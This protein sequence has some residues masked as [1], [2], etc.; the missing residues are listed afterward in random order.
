MKQ[1][2]VSCSI[3]S[4]T[5]FCS[6]GGSW[7]R[8]SHKLGITQPVCAECGEFPSSYYIKKRV[9]HNLMDFRYN[10]K[11]LKIRSVE[12]ALA[13]AQ[14]IEEEVRAGSFD[15]RKYQARK[16]ALYTIQ[17][18][19]SD[20]IQDHFL[21]LPFLSLE[22]KMFLEDFMAPYFSEVGVF[23]ACKVHLEDFVR[24]FKLRGE[25]ERMARQLFET[26]MSQVRF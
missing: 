12:Q 7:K 3:N 20:Y 17:D 6:C 18:T 9:N 22:Q 10:S 24:T 23:A 4:R 13:L 2:A 19:L 14:Q 25:K 5:E 8:T 16:C 21:K 26:V 1:S 15:R 11:G